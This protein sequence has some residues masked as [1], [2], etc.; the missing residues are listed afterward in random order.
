M[1]VSTRDATAELRYH[2]KKERY[3]RERQRDVKRWRESGMSY[4][5]IAFR[6]GV[7]VG[8]ARQIYEQAYYNQEK[9]AYKT[10]KALERERAKAA[11]E[12]K[13]LNARR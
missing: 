9:A 2:M 8:R 5:A 13:A 7:S 10:E 11:Q 6:L 12:L 4:R 1:G 3:N